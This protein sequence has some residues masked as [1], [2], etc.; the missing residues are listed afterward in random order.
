MK[1][2]N[3]AWMRVARWELLDAIDLLAIH[4]DKYAK[5][6]LRI[7]S[8]LENP[9]GH[10]NQILFRAGCFGSGYPASKRMRQAFDALQRASAGQGGSIRKK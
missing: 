6:I 3:E 5:E 10:R 2:T 1:T 4:G 7:Y 8:W 9:L